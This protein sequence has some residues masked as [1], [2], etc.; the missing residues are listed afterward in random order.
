[1]TEIS[2]DMQRI[3]NQ[4]ESQ[5]D[6]INFTNNVCIIDLGE[7]KKINSTYLKISPPINDYD[8]GIAYVS[9]HESMP[10]TSHS[11][12]IKNYAFYFEKSGSQIDQLIDF[13]S[14]MSIS[15]VPLPTLNRS[16]DYNF[17][18]FLEDTNFYV[19]VFPN[20][21]SSYK[22]GVL[23][24]LFP[25]LIGNLPDLNYQ[26]KKDP[27]TYRIIKNSNQYFVDY[28][29]LHDLFI[30]DNIE[31]FKDNILPG[32]RCIPYN[33][34]STSNRSLL[35]IIPDNNPPLSTTGVLSSFET[36]VDSISNVT[37]NTLGIRSLSP[38]SPIISGLYAYP[39]NIDSFG[40]INARYIK[41][42]F[43]FYNNDKLTTSI[44]E[45]NDSLISYYNEI[46]DLF[47]NN[48]SNEQ[49]NIY[50]NN[51]KIYSN[52][53]KVDYYG[54]PTY[55]SVYIYDRPNFEMTSFWKIKDTIINTSTQTDNSIY[56]IV[57]LSTSTE[58]PPEI[59]TKKLNANSVVGKSITNLSITK[60][61][62]ILE[63]DTIDTSNNEI[64]LSSGRNKDSTI[65]TTISLNE[66]IYLIF[67]IVVN[68]SSN[69]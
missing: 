11:R 31:S 28:G 5:A 36:I 20:Q 63:F 13:I 29:Y 51:E 25:L 48:I 58:I 23:L 43:D 19:P 45:K 16:S 22:N 61:L 47:L 53:D 46:Y 17:D 30:S 8:Y 12:E 44:K 54:N 62:Y 56:N 68:T 52:I 9:L 39:L 26:I 66:G 14:P 49:Q 1:M 3:F 64:L 15:F 37:S 50:N 10:D 57:D 67:R 65:A 7:I 35:N 55:V 42:C 41:I 18:I 2:S 60:D 24:P 27:R 34:L 40:G 33:S 32:F 38:G 69:A 6:N 4:S 21:T 59:Y